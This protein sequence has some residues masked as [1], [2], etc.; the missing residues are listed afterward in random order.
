MKGRKPTPKHLKIVSGTY[1][2]DRD[3]AAAPEMSR[4]PMIAPSWLSGRATDIFGGL[5]KLME[6][7]QTASPDYTNVV[8]ILASR[9]EEIEICT[10]MIEDFG[11]TYETENQSGSIMVR[12]RPEVSQRSEA[13]RHAQ[14]L[15]AEIGKTPAAISKVTSAADKNKNPFDEF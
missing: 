4:G 2:A 12:S 6:D 5:V 7:S 10:V 11:R 1:R 15:L 13:M 14:S 3:N 8:A 9:L